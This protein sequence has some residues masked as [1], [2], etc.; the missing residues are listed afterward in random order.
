M[1]DSVKGIGIGLIVVGALGYLGVL[2]GIFMMVTGAN[3]E[4]FR[5]FEREFGPQ[6]GN[7][8]K[9]FSQW[10]GILLGVVGSAVLIFGGLQMMRMKSWGL[11]VAAC[12]L[13][14]LPCWGCCCIGLPLGAFGLYVLFQDEIKA[15]FT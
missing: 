14:M 10:V 8:I 4:A 7:A 9:L 11:C 1:K 13:A 12:G 5:D 15:S 6:A 3:D 2:A